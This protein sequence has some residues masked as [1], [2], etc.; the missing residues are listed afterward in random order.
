[1][2]R[3]IVLLLSTVINTTGITHKYQNVQ[4]GFRKI[5]VVHIAKNF[6]KKGF[7]STMPNQETQKPHQAMTYRPL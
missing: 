3:L 5:H 4:L 7:K 2:H 6:A 1:V